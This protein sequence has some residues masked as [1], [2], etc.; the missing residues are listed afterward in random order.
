MSIRE[1]KDIYLIKIAKLVATRS[2]C[3]RK[4]VGCII[5][6]SHGHIKATGYNGT[7]K[8]YQHCSDDNCVKNKSSCLAIHA[9]QNALL[10]CTDVMDI[11]T[12]YVTMSP[13]EVCA[14]MI[15]NTSCVKLVYLDEYRDSSGLN[16]LRKIGLEVKRVRV[17]D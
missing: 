6:N 1:D 11:H 13:C 3:P 15:A 4:S 16:I 12:I 2:T 14:K 7:P 9:E 10:Q 5:T 17:E 8:N